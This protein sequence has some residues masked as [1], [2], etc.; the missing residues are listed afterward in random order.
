MLCSGVG[1]RESRWLAR[2]VLGRFGKVQ[3]EQQQQGSLF[4]SF[5]F[6]GEVPP[7]TCRSAS[8]LARTRIALSAAFRIL[9]NAS[10][11]PSCRCARGERP[12]A[13]AGVALSLSRSAARG[14]K[15]GSRRGA[16][17]CEC[18]LRRRCVRPG[19][20]QGPDGITQVPKIGHQP[21]R[22]WYNFPSSGYEGAYTLSLVRAP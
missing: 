14:E 4:F 8:F 20:G 9:L 16:V 3:Q 5:Y 2:L 19:T 18:D 15:K 7:A 10:M 13:A 11:W 17:P 22:P 6:S 1:W 12:R 21:A